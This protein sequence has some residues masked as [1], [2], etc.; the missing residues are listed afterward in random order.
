M[1]YIS[2]EIHKHVF[3]RAKGLCEYCQTAQKIVIS[4]E[5]DHIL[6]I[7]LGGVTHSDNLCVACGFCNQYKKAVIKARDPQTNTIQPLFN[8]RQQNWN[9]HFKWDESGTKVVGLTPVGRATIEQLQ[10]NHPLTVNARQLWVIAGWH[11]PK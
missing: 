2:K 10:M 3:E 1:A 11:P 6:P 9:D 8:P 4:L 7:S 5:I